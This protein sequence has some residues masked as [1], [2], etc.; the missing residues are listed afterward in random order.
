M[1]NRKVNKTRN[2]WKSAFIILIIML[3]PQALIARGSQEAGREFDP[4]LQNAIELL[5]E[6]VESG[7]ITAAEARAE[8]SDLSVQYKIEN[9]YEYRKMLGMFGDLENGSE[10]ADRVRDQLHVVSDEAQQKDMLMTQD[11][12]Q[13][14]DGDGEC[15]CDQDK[16][17][18]QTRDKDQTNKK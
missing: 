12:E 17:Q 14:K 11:R 3:I 2:Y 4:E 1:K 5:I 13:D 7:E 18:D 16:D 6:E 9:T 10:T 15:D 8:L